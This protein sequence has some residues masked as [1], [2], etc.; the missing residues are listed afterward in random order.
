MMKPLLFRHTFSNGIE[1]SLRVARD[2]FG[3]A[4]MKSDKTNFHKGIEKEYENWCDMIAHTIQENST[5]EE[6]LID[7]INCLSRL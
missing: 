4:S 5:P 1:V 7:A 6:T 3:R 2:E